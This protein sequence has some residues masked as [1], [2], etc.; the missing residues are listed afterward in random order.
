M[1]G[2]R[3]R[4]AAPGRPGASTRQRGN[5]A[6]DLALAHLQAAGL[7][8]VRRNFRTPGRGG[9]EI[10]LIMREA[11]GTLVFVEVRQRRDD[12][13]GGAAASITAAKQARLLHAARLYLAGQTGPPPC[14]FDAVLI[15]AGQLTWLRN[16]FGENG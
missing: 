5:A 8:L 15:E 14:R 13:Y 7:R 12:R 16:A 11:D 4:G 6:E 2:F 10:D 3:E 9:G 1:W